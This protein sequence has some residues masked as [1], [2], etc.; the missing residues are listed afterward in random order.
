VR[1]G[2]GDVM[3]RHTHTHTQTE[4]KLCKEIAVVLP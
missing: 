4:G 2:G 3:E 1:R